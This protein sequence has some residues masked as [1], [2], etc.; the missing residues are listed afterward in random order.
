PHMNVAAVVLFLGVPVAMVLYGLFMFPVANLFLGLRF[1]PSL[2]LSL[3]IA[4]FLLTTLALPVTSE[5]GLMVLLGAWLGFSRLPS[6]RDVFSAS[7]TLAFGGK[8]Q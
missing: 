4:V 1:M 8:R 2:G 5:R 7:R 3:G 6:M